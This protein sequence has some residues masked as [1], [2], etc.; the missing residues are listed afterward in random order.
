MISVERT[1]FEKFPRLANGPARRF[2]QPVVEALRAV[3][4]EEQINRTLAQLHPLSGFAFIARALE[5][6]NVDCR[7][8][9][10][11]RE[12]IPSEG[13]AIIVANHPL[14]ALDALALLH[15]V[16]SVRR[17]VRIL[18]N[19]VLAALAPL[20]ELLLPVRT[21]GTGISTPASVR[22][23]YRALGAEQ[24]LIVFPAGEVSRIAPPGVRD[25]RW[26]DGFVRIA[27]RMRAP[28][29]P[30]HIAARNSAV[31]YGVSMLA[32]PLSSLLLPREM[33]GAARSKLAI[34]VGETIPPDALAAAPSSAA[35][36]VRRHI[37][38][39]GKRRAGLFST[40]PCIA[41]PEPPLV[42]RAALQQ[43]QTLVALADGKRALLIDTPDDSPVLRELGRLREL[44]FRSVGEGSGQRRDIDRFDRHYRQL[45]LW[46]DAAQAII[47]AYRIGEGAEILRGGGIDGLYSASLF[48]YAPAAREFLVQGLE[49]GRSFV[50]PAYWRSRALDFLWQGLGAYLQARPQI[51]YL[52]GPVSMS[53]R[54]AQPAREWI[55]HFHLHYFGAADPLATARREFP[56]SKSVAREADALWRNQDARS[57]F[58]LLK[59]RLAQWDAQIPI[60]F[61]RYVEL[62]EPAG[63]RFLAFGQDPL[64]AGCVDGLI[65]LDISTLRTSKRERYF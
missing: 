10:A 50:Q 32:K 26:S 59:R 38:C 46:D 45:V 61:R 58:V 57:A 22:A 23:A 27:R 51:R 1:F 2:A 40:V 25:G 43:A 16:G 48:D 44:S 30:V 3:I 6:L 18:A 63:V 5:I 54:L 42:L 19:E 65:R 12:N 21:F 49:L 60:L 56:I 55:A 37:Y 11:A 8:A 62:C 52:F 15:L 29:V 24:A 13:R 28:V 34:E 53:A 20:A 9:D 31:F 4:C 7:V 14:G 39:L 47:G 17:D 35:D 36:T 64:F 41:H 33:L